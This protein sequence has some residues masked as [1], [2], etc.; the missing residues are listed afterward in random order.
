MH[1][2]KIAITAEPAFTKF[3]NILYYIYIFSNLSILTVLYH[4]NT[5]YINIHKNTIF[6][7]CF[8]SNEKLT[9]LYVSDMNT[10]L[11]LKLCI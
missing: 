1:I 8:H 6:M 11:I 3:C 2:F 5:I 4:L 7:P 9:L 10:Y